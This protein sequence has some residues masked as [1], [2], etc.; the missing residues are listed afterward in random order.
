VTTVNHIIARAAKLGIQAN[1]WQKNGK[2]RIYAKTPKYLSV[3]LEIDGT[4][5]NVEG[6]SFKVFCNTQGQHPNWTKSQVAQ[7]R[8]ENIGLFYGYLVEQYAHL[9]PSPNG[10]DQDFNDMLD[11]ARAFV[12]AKEAEE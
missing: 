8:A 4:P 12:A 6:A 10:Y 7:A 3:Y 2:L 11:K 5:D 1:C 9:G